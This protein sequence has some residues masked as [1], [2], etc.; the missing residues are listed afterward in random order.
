MDARQRQALSGMGVPLGVIQHLLVGPPA[1]S[2]HPGSQP[3]HAPRLADLGHL[4]KALPQVAQAGEEGTVGLAVP[5]RRQL[6]QQ[7]SMLSPTSVLEMP[8]ERAARR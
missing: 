8:T 4:R 6:G 1:G 5:Q 3:I 7:Q 2:Q